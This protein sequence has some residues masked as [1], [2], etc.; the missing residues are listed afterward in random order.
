MASNPP[1]APTTPACP[2]GTFLAVL[3]CFAEQWDEG[4]E[5]SA[6]EVDADEAGDAGPGQQ[7][8]R[9]ARAQLARISLVAI[10]REYNL[11]FAQLTGRVA[12][13]LG[14]TPGA[15]PVKAVVAQFAVL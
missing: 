8:P 13:A 5:E 4:E 2:Q 3:R 7:S 12:V 15:S 9:Q 10:L 6:A 11:A 14:D 1:A